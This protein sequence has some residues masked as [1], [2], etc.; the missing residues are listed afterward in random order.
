MAHAYASRRSGTVPSGLP[1]V[2]APRRATLDELGIP[3]RTVAKTGVVGEL[4]SGEPVVALRADMD[5]LPIQVRRGWVDV[6][7][8]GRQRR[9]SGTGLDGCVGAQQRQSR[10]LVG[11]CICAQSAQAPSRAGHVPWQD[12]ARQPEREPAGSRGACACASL[13]CAPRLLAGLLVVL[14]QAS[15]LR[16]GGERAGL[17]LEEAKRHARL[18]ARRPHQHAAGRWALLPG[19]S[20]GLRPAL[21]CAALA[22]ALPLSL[23]PALCTAGLLFNTWLAYNFAVRVRGCIPSSAAAA[24]S[25]LAGPPEAAPLP[26]WLPSSQPPRRSRAWSR[27]C[28]A[29]CACS[30]SRR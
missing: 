11:A 25:T 15:L 7:V 9:P 13:R 26:P 8:G 23:Q 16:A 22:T 24:S 1:H 3:H 2:P 18:R 5:A 14:S 21:P 4:G 28:R 30:S 10:A 19:A 17:C 29:P 20:A 27:S 6:F 12:M